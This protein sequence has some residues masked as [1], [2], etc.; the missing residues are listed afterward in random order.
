VIH[1]AQT[2]LPGRRTD[3]DLCFNPDRQD[4]NRASQRG[5]VAIK[6]GAAQFAANVM[7]VVRQ[8]EAAGITT[9]DGIAEAMNSNGIATPHGGKWHAITV[10]NLWR[11]KHEAGGMTIDPATMRH[12]KQR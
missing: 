7:P 11:G 5:V 2:A 8:I 10:A 6:A 3:R 1:G 9:L 4:Q 12:Q